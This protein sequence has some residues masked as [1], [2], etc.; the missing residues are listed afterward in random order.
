MMKFVLFALLLS[1]LH[2]VA[3]DYGQRGDKL[4]CEEALEY[5]VEGCEIVD[6]H[7]GYGDRDSDQYDRECIEK[8]MQGYSELR[9][10]AS[11]V[12]YCYVD[13]DQQD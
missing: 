4:T 6:E 5:A 12:P 7:G 10:G 11:N 3:E 1:G 2:V 9:F 13:Y 8:K